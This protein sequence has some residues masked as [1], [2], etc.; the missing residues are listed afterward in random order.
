MWRTCGMHIWY[1]LHKEKFQMP[2][3]QALKTP[4]QIKRCRMLWTFTYYLQYR[5]IYTRPLQLAS[6]LTMLSLATDSLVSWY[7]FRPE[8]LRY[9]GEFV[10]H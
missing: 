8:W 7:S 4:F 1:T 5:N 10:E 2:C 9:F 6:L 3:V